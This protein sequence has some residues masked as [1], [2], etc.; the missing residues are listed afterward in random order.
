MDPII[1]LVV[2]QDPVSNEESLIDRDSDVF[3]TKIT[4]SPI[5]VSRDNLS[6][7]VGKQIPFL[8]VVQ[9]TIA[10]YIVEVVFPFSEFIGWCT[11]QYSQEEKVIVNKQGSEVLCRVEGLSIQSALDILDS[12][13]TMSKPFEEENLIMVYRECPSEVKY[14]FLQTILKPEHLSESLSLPM[15]V[16]VMFIEVQWVCSLPS[17]IL[18]LDN[19]KHV[20]EVKLGFMLAFFQ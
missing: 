3:D 19:E 20:V 9:A 15:S 8:E 18:G 12:F 14:L 5:S 2:E 17:Q 7:N 10:P 13:S 1:I 16:S 4:I 11:E 6:D